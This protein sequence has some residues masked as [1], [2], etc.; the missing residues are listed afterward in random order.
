MGSIFSKSEPEKATGLRVE[1]LKKFRIVLIGNNGVGKSS[2]ISAFS[3]EE[4]DKY[5]S[6]VDITVDGIDLKIYDTNNFDNQ[7]F[8]PF[9]YNICVYILVYEVDSRESFDDID[10]YI[11]YINKKTH[12]RDPKFYLVG[13]KIDLF[14][15]DDPDMVSRDEAS[16]KAKELET[17]LYLI[18]ASKKMH[19]DT[20]L[21]YLAHDIN[22]NIDY[23]S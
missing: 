22:S 20:F 10:K 11:D 1:R 23:L 15:D 5:I 9:S 3:E 21:D 2:L 18:S 7:P 14:R 12:M 8:I 19:V 13:N 4:H 16:K 17:D 6:S